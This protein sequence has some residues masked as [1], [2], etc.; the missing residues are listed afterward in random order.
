VII[1][2]AAEIERNLKLSLGDGDNTVTV[3][4]TIDGS[5]MYDGRD[6]DDVITIAETAIIADSVFARLGDGNNSVTHNGQI[7]GDLNVVSANEDDTVTVAETAV[8][9][10]K[11]NLGLGEQLDFFARCGHGGS[12]FGMFGVGGRAMGFF[13]R[14]FQ[15]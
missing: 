5:V 10:G 15:R 8:V 6:G 14:G 12:E 13:Y 2:A 7:D 9:G 11:T 4:G 1:D 3:A